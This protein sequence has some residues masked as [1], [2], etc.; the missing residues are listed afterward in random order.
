M[1]VKP[2]IYS[3]NTAIAACGRG[4]HWQKAMDLLAGMTLE[5]IKPNVFTYNA[6][7]GVCATAGQYRIG[8]EL[9]AKVK[10][11]CLAL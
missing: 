10:M 4:G 3:F 11:G 7:I 1:H 9:L 2:D 5:G 6:A 8:L